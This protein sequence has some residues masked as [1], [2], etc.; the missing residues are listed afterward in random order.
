[1]ENIINLNLHSIISLI[2]PL[3]KPTP[4]NLQIE[5]PDDETYTP[6]PQIQQNNKENEEND[7]NYEENEENDDNYEE[8]NNLWNDEFI[9]NELMIFDLL[10]ENEYFINYF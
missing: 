3:A 5:I 4:Q 6:P 9:L 1:M 8:N 7:D 2:T 10:L